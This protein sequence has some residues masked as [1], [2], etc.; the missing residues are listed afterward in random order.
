MA[1]DDKKS[2]GSPGKAPGS[3][4]IKVKGTEDLGD[5]L[6]GVP[7]K[8]NNDGDAESAEGRGKEKGDKK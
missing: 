5:E 1:K 2:G 7:G 6:K 8:G 3:G 4:Y